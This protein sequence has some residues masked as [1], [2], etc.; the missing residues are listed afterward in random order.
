MKLKRMC[1]KKHF[2]KRTGIHAVLEAAKHS[3]TIS[4]IE[5]ETRCIIKLPHDID[6]SISVMLSD[7]EVIEPEIT[8]G[9]GSVLALHSIT[10]MQLLI[11]FSQKRGF[12]PLIG[13]TNKKMKEDDYA[14]LKCCNNQENK[15]E[16]INFS[17]LFLFFP[18][19]LHVFLLKMLQATP[20]FCFVNSNYMYVY[21]HLSLLVVFHMKTK[22]VIQ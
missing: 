21:V 1:S 20:Q 9:N 3:G 15:S 16:I 7:Y 14:I 10:A 19:V 4:G 18:S 13:I 12:L 8:E 22:L 6:E 2:L 11:L 5:K 17:A